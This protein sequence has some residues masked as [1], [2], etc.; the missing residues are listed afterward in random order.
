[1]NDRQAH[2]ERV[3]RAVLLGLSEQAERTW[4]RLNSF[5]LMQGNRGHI[6]GGALWNE[7]TWRQL[8]LRGDQI[9]ELVAGGAVIVRG[10]D[11]WLI[12]YD[13]AEQHR[14]DHDQWLEDQRGRK[15]R[16]R[17]EEI[18]IEIPPE[19]PPTPEE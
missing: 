12:G 1:V 11:L 13:H 9:A 8:G 3:R 6:T 7:E 14:L 4:M 15:E 5:C 16:E 10:D 19:D 17:D 18:V 2:H